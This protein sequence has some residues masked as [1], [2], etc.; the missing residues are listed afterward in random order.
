MKK[1]ANESILIDLGVQ[2]RLSLYAT[3]QFS[4]SLMHISSAER[5]PRG[6]ADA[7][8]SG[9]TNEDGRTKSQKEYTK[10][11]PGKLDR[12]AE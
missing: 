11:T 9:R 7:G 5:Q 1:R 10:R 8:K 4:N 3:S 2:D 6:I 12:K